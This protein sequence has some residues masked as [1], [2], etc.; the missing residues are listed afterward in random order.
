[1]AEREMPP[2]VDLIWN[3]TLVCPYDCAVCCV[4]AVHVSRRGGRI[5]LRS[6]A[7]TNSISGDA[8]AGSI[9]EQAGRFRQQRGL[10]LDLDGKLRVLEHLKGCRARLD[11]SGGDVLV[12][13]E[14]LEVI[15]AAAASFGREMITVTA[16]SAGV[17]N[18]LLGPLASIIGHFNFTYDGTVSTGG[19]RPPNYAMANLKAGERL[20]REGVS[21]RA[22]LP[23]SRSNMDPAELSRIYEALR[24]S[25][26]GQIL[27]MR[28][29]P[30][31]RGA[32]RVAEIPSRA[33]YLSSIRHLRKLEETGGPRVRLQCALRH[34]EGNNTIGPNPCNA[35][36]ESFGIAP[37]GTLLRSAWAIDR[38]GKPLDP[39]WVLGNVASTSLEGILDTDRV[40]EMRARAEENHGHC[41]VFAFLNGTSPDPADRFFEKSDPLYAV[42]PEAQPDDVLHGVVV[43]ASGRS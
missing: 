5:E 29:F 11:F 12:M 37:D 20:A 15:R 27:V 28:L 4:D 39:S 2:F 40:K 21:V 34:L 6:T 22:E 3:M 10:E 1:M 33:E 16:T 9:Y 38:R 36:T 17:R 19:N 41:K 31:G 14:N 13:E 7:G 43:S 30:V 8:K 26:V 25:G 23:L 24:Q 18:A 42:S 32:D 35:V